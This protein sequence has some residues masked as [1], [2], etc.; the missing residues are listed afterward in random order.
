MV[1][2]DVRPMFQACKQF[3]GMQALHPSKPYLQPAIRLSCSLNSLVPIAQYFRGLRMYV[4]TALIRAQAQMPAT[5]IGPT[6][7]HQLPHAT[8]LTLLVNRVI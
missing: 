3:S 1:C 4:L 6:L 7:I 5:P 8:A 2:V